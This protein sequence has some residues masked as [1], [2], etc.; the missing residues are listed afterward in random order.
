MYARFL[1]LPLAAGAAL[2]AAQ[3][4]TAQS[5]YPP[6]EPMLTVSPATIFTGDCVVVTGAGYGP[7]EA[8]E[9]V[10]STTPVAA[11]QFEQDGAEQSEP[12]ALRPVAQGTCASETCTPAAVQADGMVS[13]DG[14]GAFS[15]TRTLTEVGQA[16]I[17]ATGQESG[18]SASAVVTVLACGEALP[19]TGSPFLRLVQVGAA[20]AGAGALLLG[21][22][23]WR[24]RR[25]RVS[26]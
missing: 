5:P 12:I 21:W 7:G 8:V 9:L 23:V 19:E 18:L 1:L 11:P 16:T 26:A 4:A 14:E 2:L 6:T 24:R 10:V 3:P 25:A 17:T 22:L 20:A 15:T 13:T